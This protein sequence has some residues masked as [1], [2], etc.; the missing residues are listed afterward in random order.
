MPIIA[1]R[2]AASAS[3]FGQRQG[4]KTF[5]LHYMIVAGGG[6]GGKDLAGGGGAGGFRV[7]FGSSPLSSQSEIS[8]Q[9]PQSSDMDQ[10]KVSP[11]VS[12][13][14]SGTRARIKT[15]FQA[16]GSRGVNS[17]SNKLLMTLLPPSTA[18]FKLEIDDLEIKKQGQEQ[19]QSE[20]DKGLRT[21]LLYTS[22]AADE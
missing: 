14:T 22:D 19:M 13:Q 17:L 16:T 5:D 21:C 2:G 10:N 8:A 18:F 7:S 20:I 9:Q 4:A 15:P 3:G 6:S 12:E 1:S 11:G